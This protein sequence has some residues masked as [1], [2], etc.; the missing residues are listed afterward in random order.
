MKGVIES[1]DN[2]IIAEGTPDEQYVIDVRIR[3]YLHK[4]NDY[5]EA[6]KLTLGEVE[7]TQEENK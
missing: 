5:K 2:P 3:F 4:T 7:L 6:K 1:I